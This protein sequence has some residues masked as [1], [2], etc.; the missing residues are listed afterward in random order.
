MSLSG[1]FQR[2]FSELLRFDPNR[3]FSS[4]VNR[5]SLLLDVDFLHLLLDLKI[6]RT[7]RSVALRTVGNDRRRIRQRD[8][9]R[10]VETFSDL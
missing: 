7:R 6:D 3:K 9:R 10:S 4:N 8:P 1:K 2:V 5:A